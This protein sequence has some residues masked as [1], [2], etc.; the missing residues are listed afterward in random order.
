MKTIYTSILLL[1]TVAATA[2]FG[3]TDSSSDTSVTFGIAET[4]L[5]LGSA[6]TGKY[7]DFSKLVVQDTSYDVSFIPTKATPGFSFFPTSNSASRSAIIKPNGTFELGSGIA[8]GIVSKSIAEILGFY[9]SENGIQTSLVKFNTPQKAGINPMAFNEQFSYIV[10]YVSENII[11]EVGTSKTTGNGS[12][13]VKFDATGT[14]LFPGSKVAVDASRYFTSET[15]VDTIYEVIDDEDYIVR[16]ESKKTF[17]DISG[18][19]TV[20]Q[21]SLNVSTHTSTTTVVFPKKLGAPPMTETVTSISYSRTTNLKE[22]KSFLL[23]VENEEVLFSKI[24][25]YPHPSSGTVHIS[26]IENFKQLEI[27]NYGYTRF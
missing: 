17:Y 27:L 11:P 18:N 2:Q 21:E 26:G 10:D 20:K 25:L 13:I 19:N 23:G 16:I 8:F 4:T 6:G 3:P 9:D 24:K 7:W 5:N 15:V 22:I 12:G 1:T 14:V